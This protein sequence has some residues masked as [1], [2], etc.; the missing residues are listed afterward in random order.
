MPYDSD[1]PYYT[2][3]SF[4]SSSTGYATLD[5]SLRPD[6]MP[7]LANCFMDT[8]GD[9]VMPTI[10]CLGGTFYD[11]VE[12]KGT[13]IVDSAAFGDININAVLTSVGDPGTDNSLVTEK[14]IRDAINE[15]ETDLE[16]YVDQEIATLR[17]YVDQQIAAVLA[18]ANTYSDANAY[19]SISQAVS[20]AV[21]AAVSQANAYTDAAI[22]AI[23]P[24][25][26]PDSA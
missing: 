8:E 9:F 15:L 5:P 7:P 6:G 2:D 24:P 23:P 10:K 11:T 17:A 22:A 12:F 18:S 1:F 4:D 3:S 26:P 25:T 20:Q 16:E 13:I 14:G 21:P 19:W